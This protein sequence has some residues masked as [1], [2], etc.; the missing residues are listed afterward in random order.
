LSLLVRAVETWILT[1]A[2]G[3]YPAG[4]TTGFRFIARPIRFLFVNRPNVSDRVVRNTMVYLSAKMVRG[5]RPLILREN[6]PKLR[7]V[8]YRP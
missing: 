7:V 3:S 8:E 5:G 6:W 2:T 1:D 4:L